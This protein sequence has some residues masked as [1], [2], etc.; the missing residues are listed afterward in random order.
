MKR[1]II[2]VSLVLILILGALAGC[3]AKN[4]E[5][6]EE[7]PG[8]SGQQE[9][10]EK[11]PEPAA[12]GNDLP[13]TGNREKNAL[14]VNNMKANTLDRAYHSTT[15][16]DRVIN[17][18]ADTLYRMNPE[19]G[20]DPCLATS[21]EPNEDGTEVLITLRDDV[22]F[23]DGTKF[24][25][26]DVKF[27]YD[28]MLN[29]QGSQL[30][31]NS[32]LEIIDDLHCRIVFTTEGFTFNNL[33]EYV[34]QITPLNSAYY[35]AKYDDPHQDLLFDINATGP[36]DLVDVNDADGMYVFR[37]WD[38]YWGDRG[39]ID[40]ITTRDIT[41]DVRLPYEAGDIDYAVYT[42]D[43]LPNVEDYDNVR[44]EIN[45]DGT[46]Y[47][48]ICNT[49]KGP[50]TDIRIRE[51][52]CYAFDRDELAQLATGYAGVTAWNLVGPNITFYHDLLPHRLID[53]DKAR[54]MMSEAGYSADNPCE[55]ELLTT[56]N[57]VWVAA[58]EALK[59]NLDQCY[60]NC[61]ISKATD[62]IPYFSG[63]FDLGMLGIGLGASFNNY[64]MLY[65]P[66][67]GLN[68]SFYAGDD[69]DQLISEYA[70]ATTQEDADK[71]MLHEDSLFC[72]IPVAY[73]ATIT[74]FNSDLDTSGAFIG[75]D[76][77]WS[78]MKWK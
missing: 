43:L 19:S 50:M 42:Y 45:F 65:S 31:E 66:D 14:T 2:A 26:A 11:T 7:Q 36:Y 15:Y 62:F 75:G 3:G 47:Y 41:G 12:S 56:S 64:A 30:P 52:V 72:Y 1:R 60:F 8:Q 46:L 29:A 6:P 25:S 23:R 76:Y 63:S 16:E 38:G 58:I 54:A 27:G 20:F 57:P 44:V 4:E 32:K 18:L 77:D 40:T 69:L 59:E 13:T 35:Y 5:A 17:L 51:A 48:L 10:G 34:Y 74:A 28:H 68:L 78:L 71:A 21:I 53:Q 37:K 49:A 73:S 9:Q 61:H 22:Y 39:Y 67:A 24:S 33:Y 70:T 55:L